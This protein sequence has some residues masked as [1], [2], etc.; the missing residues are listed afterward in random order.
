MSLYASSYKSPIG[1]LGILCNESS[2]YHIGISRFNLIDMYDDTEE[3]DSEIIVET[4]LWLDTYF[5][6][7]KPDFTPQLELYG[8][9]FQKKVWNELLSIPFGQTTTYGEIAKR[10]GCRCAQAVGQVIGQNPILI[11]VPCHRVVAA[12][13]KIGGF[14]AGIER[15]RWLLE[16]EKQI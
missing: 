12:G 16:N 15:K 13:G 11:I 2:V 8:T 7:K 10:V 9:V 4:K 5:S 1:V 3:K 14:S 6:G